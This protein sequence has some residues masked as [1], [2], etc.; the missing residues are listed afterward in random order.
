LFPDN[1]G[2]SQSLTIS[3]DGS[4]IKTTNSGESFDDGSLTFLYDPQIP[5]ISSDLSSSWARGS[6]STFFL[7]TSFAS[8]VSIAGLPPGIDFNASSSILSG[9][10]ESGGQFDISITASNPAASTLQTHRLHILDPF[11]FSAK[12]ELV[13]NLSSLGQVPSDF[14]GLAMHLDA[15]QLDEQNGTLLD[16][17]SDSSGNER[18]LDRVRGAPQLIESSLGSSL[19]V[20][21]FDGMTQMYSSYDFGGLLNDYTILTVA[22]HTGGQNNAVIA[23]VGSDWVFGLGGEKSGYWKLGGT[24]LSGP[25][26]DDS[27]HLL[28]G[29]L[30]QA[31]A[32]SLRRDGYEVASGSVSFS[33]DTKPRFLGLGGANA[34][35]SFS[36]SEIS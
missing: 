34:N 32:V 15:S 12:L 22:R 5:V 11:A 10:P 29:T 18:G 27:W 3:I 17:W 36:K 14:P 8:S 26:A 1:N 23:S 33:A 30:N 20:V 16:D 9:V 4:Q 13:P 28:S 21:R 19:K 25:S 35:D 31:G 2:S 7:K 24:V 6:Y